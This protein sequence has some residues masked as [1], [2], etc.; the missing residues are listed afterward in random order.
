MSNDPIVISEPEM[1]VAEQ[2]RREDAAP[3]APWYGV[4][5]RLR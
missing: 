2:L 3:G 5:T 1:T 4:F